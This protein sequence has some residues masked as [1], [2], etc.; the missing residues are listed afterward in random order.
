MDFETSTILHRLTQADKRSIS[1]FSISADGHIIAFK[2][3]NGVSRLC[4]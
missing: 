1:D 4:I 3:Y 2:S